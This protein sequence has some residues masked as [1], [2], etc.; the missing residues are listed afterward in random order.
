ME[1]E[2]VG[3]KKKEREREKF[4]LPS[5]KKKKNGDE[6][7]EDVEKKKTCTKTWSTKNQYK[8]SLGECLIS[9]K[10]F[11]CMSEYSEM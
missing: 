10:K 11:L 8:I 7:D 2:I 9:L 1:R 4:V 6:W 5:S 3:V